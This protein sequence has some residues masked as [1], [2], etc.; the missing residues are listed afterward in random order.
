MIGDTFNFEDVFFRDLT[1]CVLDTL[2]GQ[3]KWVNRFTS[4]DVFVQV[5]I[6]YSLT[7]D[8]RFLLDSFS[9][10]I[11]SENRF[12][13]LNTDLIPRGHLTMTGFNIKSDEFANPNVWLR[14]VVENEFEI[15]KV[16]GKV[17]AVP[18]TVN[19]DLEITLSSE[20]DTFKCSQAILDTLWIYRFMYFEHN[21]MN[22]DAILLMPD[23]NS[24]E[25]SREKNL[26]SDNNIKLKCSFTVETYY[27]AFR[28]DRIIDEGY[29]REYG[30]GMSDGNGFTI[31]G[32]VSDYFDA[33]DT[34]TV[35]AG[36]NTNTGGGNTN[37]GGG[38]TN[39]GGGNTN[40][41]GGNTNTGG[42]NTNTGGSVNVNKVNTGTINS[43]E[44][45]GLNNNNNG[46]RHGAPTWVEGPFNPNN[47]LTPHGETGS[48]YNTGA[49]ANASDVY[50]SFAKDRVVIPKRSRWFNNILK[51]RERASS[52]NNKDQIKNKPGSVEK[53]GDDVFM[54]KFQKKDK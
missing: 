15:R 24:I 26:T 41:G 34:N 16:L 36:G 23:T 8:E 44:S 46:G 21:F 4:G 28:R 11:V 42:G 17:R 25:M 53:S 20:I 10:D 19:Y 9:D 6:Y 49:N 43:N 35:F 39:T 14:M 30:S 33:N 52:S 40:T 1:V 13:E 22:I 3:I 7:G 51:A 32:G 47:P 48:F 29:S 31:T 37:T 45:F 12:I 38:N 50:G 27:P 2:E 54:E 18:I 5:P